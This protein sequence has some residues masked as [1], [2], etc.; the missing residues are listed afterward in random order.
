M[1]APLTPMALR[2]AVWY[3]GESN[4]EEARAYTRLLPA[5]IVDWRQNFQNPEMA[6]Y[7]VQLANFGSREG[8][9]SKWAE[10]REAQRSAL[11]VRGTG[12]VVTIDVGDPVDIHPRNKQAVG[13]RLAEQA[14]AKHYGIERVSGVC[15]GPLA[16]GAKRED[17][18]AR[19]WFTSVG[20]GLVLHTGADRTF[21]VA[22]ADGVF[23]PA[24][25]RVDGE[26]VIVSSPRV[27]HVSSVR[28]G[29]A[30][31]PEATLF[32][33]VGYPG[34]PFRLDLSKE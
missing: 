16:V 12:M 32:N 6:F 33:K 5:L 7:F 8:T 9:T 13:E 3:Q 15:E 26:T 25:A 11:R 24:L 27:A 18:A 1:V 23:H 4:A 31:N 34:S 14:L 28:Y 19:I 30:D 17:S 22:G 21:E 20:D 2:G 10:L 29:W